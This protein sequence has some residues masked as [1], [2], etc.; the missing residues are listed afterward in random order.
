VVLQLRGL[1]EVL[2]TPSRE[3]VNVMNYPQDEMLP[4]QIKQSEGKLLVYNVKFVALL[5]APYI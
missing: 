4:L 1:G 5:G 3:N 2:T